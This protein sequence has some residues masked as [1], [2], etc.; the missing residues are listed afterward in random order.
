M[1]Q[2]VPVEPRRDFA[3]DILTG[4]TSFA[5]V[6]IVPVERLRWGDACTREGV[7]F[8]GF[9]YVATVPVERLRWGDACTREGVFFQ[10]KEDI[11]LIVCSSKEWKPCILFRVLIG[12]AY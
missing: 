3:V 2:I 9:A 1:L 11:V 10:G 6:A 12:S 4:W 8:Q 5:Y 7:F